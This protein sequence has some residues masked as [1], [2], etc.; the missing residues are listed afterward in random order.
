MSQFPVRP[1]L[2]IPVAVKT[3]SVKLPHTTVVKSTTE[4]V[5]VTYLRA[6]AEMKHGRNKGV[7]RNEKE[8]AH[9][10]TAITAV[11]FLWL[12]ETS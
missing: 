12:Q 8:T 1:H 10:V 7:S 6:R 3:G 9:V 4:R 11:A 2:R 5:V